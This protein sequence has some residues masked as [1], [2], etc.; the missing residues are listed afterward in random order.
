MIFK[1]NGSISLYS[2]RC[3]KGANSLNQGVWKPLDLG[4]ADVCALGTPKPRWLYS[5]NL[6]ELLLH[7]SLFCERNGVVSV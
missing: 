2:A 3:Y 5:G 6:S 1:R 7:G 4:T